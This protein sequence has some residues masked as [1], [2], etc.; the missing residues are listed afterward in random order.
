MFRKLPHIAVWAL[1]VVLLALQLPFLEADP[2]LRLSGSR[3]PFTDE[4]LYSA[5]VRN[6]IQQGDL[7]FEEA[8]SAVVTP[9]FSLFLYVVFSIF[10]INLWVGRLA[11]LLVSLLLIKWAAVKSKQSWD[12]QMFLLSIVGTSY[13]L[14]S[15][16][17]FCLA[18]ML[19]ASCIV[20]AIGFQAANFENPTTLRT[21]MGTGFLFAAFLLKLQFLY[22]LPLL[23]MVIFLQLFLQT[24]ATQK[25]I[26][27]QLFISISTL[28]LLSLLYFLF[29]Y[30]P[31]KALFQHIMSDATAGRFAA[32][33]NLPTHIKFILNV[34]FWNDFQWVNSLSFLV[35][36]PFGIWSLIRKE[37]KIGY[38]IL[39]ISGFCWVLLESHKLIL[40]YYP[41]RYFVSFYL[42]IALCNG[43][44]LYFL[45]N[46]KLQNNWQRIL[47]SVVLLGIL[48]KN[49]MDYVSGLQQRQYSLKTINAYLA[50]YDLGDRPVMGAWAPS[51]S[52]RNK[53]ASYPIWRDYFNDTAVFERFKPAVIISEVDEEDSNQA[54]ST[55]GISLDAQADSIK[56]FKIGKWDLKLLWLK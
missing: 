14:L 51:V 3:G 15:Y 18:E 23:P 35:L 25:A 37:E 4:G 8:P 10:G 47:I 26:G 1:F 52:W 34:L 16:T 45:W 24:K 21:V 36:L 40:T 54:F 56:Y 7:T 27:K 44:I 31:N 39:L 43:L 41:T 29:W 2:D 12:F 50:A 13:V 53:A 33:G 28:F 19:A 55:K 48:F 5:Q 22:I 6:L 20:V 42:A 32:L 38:K 17:H 9:L 46:L 11:V 30:L 49:G